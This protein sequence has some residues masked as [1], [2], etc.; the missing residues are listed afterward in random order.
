MAST[1]VSTTEAI[2]DMLITLTALP[3]SSPSLFLDLEG[4]QLSRQGSI[5]IMQIFAEPNDHVYLVDVHTL[6]AAAFSTPA[7][8]GKTTLKAL[9][10]DITIPKVF[11][12]VRNDSDALFFHYQIGL[13]GV[14]D[15]QLM[16]NASRGPIASKRLL[17]GLKKC[18]QKNASISLAAKQVWNNIKERGEE[19]YLPKHGGSYEVFNARPL[20]PDITAYCVQDV[21][22]LPKLRNFYW[23]QLDADW[24][25]KVVTE[26][27]ARVRESQMPAY[28]PYGDDKALGPWPLA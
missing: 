13:R 22:L 11:F 14:E 20:A 3:K 6:G 12:D 21:K 7:T 17:N 28:E 15:V 18:I 19:L 10:E 16:E 8:A 27:E 2:A 26:T 5:S 9:L 23:D 1:M 24:K 25:A 4:V